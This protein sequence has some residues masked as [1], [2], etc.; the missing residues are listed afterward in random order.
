[1]YCVDLRPLKMANLFPNETSTNS[2]ETCH[3]VQTDPECSSLF[4]VLFSLK[5]SSK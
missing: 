3:F 1:M 4:A 2:N 5:A